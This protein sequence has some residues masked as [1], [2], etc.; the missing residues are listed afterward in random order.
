MAENV[1]TNGKSD[2]KL[3]NIKQRFANFQPFASHV[4]KDLVG[5]DIGAD[6]IQLIQINQNETP[7][8][9]IEY[10]ESPLPAGVIIKDEIKNPAAIA[11]ALKDMVRQTGVSAKFAAVA[12]PRALAIIK[13]ITVDKRLTTDEIESRA[14]VEANRLFP[15]LVGNIYLDFFV[16][17]NS[18]AQPDQL[19]LLLVACRKE[20]I[21]PYLEILTQS[22]LIPK[23]VDVNCYALERALNLE[24]IKTPELQTIALLNVNINQSSLIVVDRGQLIHAHDQSY[25]GLRLMKQVEA[26][27]KAKH[28]EPGMAES[29]IV[30][31][32]ISYQKMLQENFISHLRHTVHFFYSSRPNVSIQKIILSGDCAV[33]PDFAAFIGQEIGIATVLADPFTNMKIHS[34]LDENVIRKHASTLMLSVGLALSNVGE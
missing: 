2:S 5:V 28:E 8:Q 13:S 23:I 1:D 9:V 20:H 16:T 4:S 25:D 30:I 18:T 26:Y 31:S 15:D 7:P 34:H 29:P 11:T 22:G 19:D 32:D 14:W 12:I 6:R 3:S 33:I 27:V 17:G 10:A 21:K 24:M